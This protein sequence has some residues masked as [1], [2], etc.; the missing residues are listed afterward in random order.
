VHQLFIVEIE[1]TQ[2]LGVEAGAFKPFRPAIV[3]QAIVGMVSQVVSWWLEHDDIAIEE[4]TDT[5][6]RMLQE[7][8]ALKE[9]SHE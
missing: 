6:A 5:V 8:I 2:A 7:G 1:E 4:I 9:S 3:A